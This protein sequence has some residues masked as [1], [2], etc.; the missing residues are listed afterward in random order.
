MGRISI[1]SAA[2]RFLIELRAVEP[3]RKPL[4]AD[5]LGRRL[6]QCLVFILSPRPLRHVLTPVLGR[7]AACN[8]VLNH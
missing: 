7:S 1:P 2:A 3:D 4:K 8:E 6:S 5:A